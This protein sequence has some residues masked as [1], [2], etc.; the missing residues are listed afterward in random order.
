MRGGSAARNG[1][2]RVKLGSGMGGGIMAAIGMTVRHRRSRADPSR[3]D[4]RETGADI[5]KSWLI[6]RKPIVL[7]SLKVTREP[8]RENLEPCEFPLFSRF[9]PQR[10]PSP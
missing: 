7:W 10:V 3:T 9:S 5:S 2:A 1:A 6:F 8:E 4:A